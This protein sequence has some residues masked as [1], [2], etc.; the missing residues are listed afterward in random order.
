MGQPTPTPVNPDDRLN[1][2][3][4]QAGT[5]PIQSPTV[6]TTTI[7]GTAPGSQ[8][9]GDNGFD[10]AG[11]A[12]GGTTPPEDPQII[13]NDKQDKTFSEASIYRQLELGWI[14]DAEAARLFGLMGYDENEAMTMVKLYYAQEK[15]ADTAPGLSLSTIFEAKEKGI[16]DQEEVQRRLSEAGYAQADIDI[17][18]ALSNKNKTETA[19]KMV[20]EGTIWQAYDAGGLGAGEV[21]RRLG[22]LGY[23]SDDINSMI[24]WRDK[25]NAQDSAK[26]AKS[27]SRYAASEQ[28]RIEAEAEQKKREAQAEVRRSIGM[29][30]NEARAA[31]PVYAGN[32]NPVKLTA[33]AVLADFRSN[34][35]NALKS[36]A[37]GASLPARQWAMDNMDAFLPMYLQSGSENGAFTLGAQQIQQAYESQRGM[38]R[39][40]GRAGVGTTQVRSI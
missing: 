8:L 37:A 20:G 4:Q 28:R 10:W 35:S 31:N 24:G 2:I 9:P 36:Q 13:P 22:E 40:S 32:E 33:P 21:A 30:P 27:E 18:T 34:F 1:K 7:Q 23:T 29:L 5:A 39:A 14:D 26:E 11:G 3:K 15:K 19:N 38:A 16:I 25:M 17:L 6:Q 12:G